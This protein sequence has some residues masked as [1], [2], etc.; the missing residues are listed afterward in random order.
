MSAKTNRLLALILVSTLAAPV[1]G[2]VERGSTGLTEV[3]F[4]ARNDAA[5]EISCAVSLAHWYSAELGRAVPGARIAV[6]FWRDPTDG[7]L[8]L[9]NEVGDRMAVQMAWCGFAGASWES[10]SVVTLAQGKPADLTCVSDTDR[11]VCR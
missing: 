6:S 4:V 2:A 5:R 11:L 10:R 1:A 9:L 8:Y 3:P 7:T